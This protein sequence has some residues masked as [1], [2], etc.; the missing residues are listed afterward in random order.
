MDAENK[1]MLKKIA[2]LAIGIFSPESKGF[3][4]MVDEWV[5]KGKMTEEEGR[6][7]VEDLMNQA[8]TIKSDLEKSLYDQAKSFYDNLHLA[9]T[10][11]LAALE[12]RIEAL[13][14]K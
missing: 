3:N 9:T 11:Q 2:Y 4:E 8:K 14:K 6:K 12:K 13:E 7:F 10:D 5:E 1:E